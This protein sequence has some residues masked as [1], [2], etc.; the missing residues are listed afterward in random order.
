M[1]PQLR[2]LQDQ[3]IVITGASS[4]IGL[5]TARMAARNGAKVILCARNQDAVRD[6][7]RELTAQGFVARAVPADVSNEADVRRLADEAIATYGRID[8]WVN[9]AAVAI[10]GELTDV[11]LED[12]RQLFE[13]DFWGVV[14]G[15]RVAVE[16]MRDDGGGAL[17]NVGSVLSDMAFP[18][19]GIYSA[20]KHAVQGYTDALR[21]ELEHDEIPISVTL[22]K[23]TA[24]DTPYTKHAKN[25]LE[26]EPKN[27]PPYYSPETV[28]EA[29]LHAAQH[30][31]RELYVGGAGKAFTTGH[32]L[33]PRLME[34]LLSGTMF[35]TQKKKERAQPREDNLYGPA[36]DGSE[37]GEGEH[38]VF[39]RSVYT[40]AAMLPALG[41]ML[42]VGA[43]L[44]SASAIKKR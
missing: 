7:E 24:I 11:S 1:K 43:A 6:I 38:V 9:N 8:T 34:R 28:A 14:H 40:K 18:L 25:Y 10:Y 2:K 3:V 20:A 36:E 31:E 15:C 23:P 26:R 35:S 33:A 32:K 30:S 27:A 22:I 17:I 16:R 41:I 12:Q 13:I 29:I 37:R 4:G 19:Q 39:E 44:L 42:I 21:M 5:A